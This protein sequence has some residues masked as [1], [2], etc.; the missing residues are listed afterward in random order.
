ASFDM[1][2]LSIRISD[3]DSR[4]VFTSSDVG[5]PHALYAARLDGS[6]AR[7]VLRTALEIYQPAW[8]PD[9]RWIALSAGAD[10]DRLNVYIA[11]RAGAMLA[12]LTSKGFA[13]CPDWS[14]KARMP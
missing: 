11:N 10:I 1:Q 12:R 13:C 9:G 3:D 7:R 8:S 4:I 5:P 14:T 6:H 2:F